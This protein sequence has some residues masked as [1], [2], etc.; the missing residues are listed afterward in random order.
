MPDEKDPRITVNEDEAT[1][2]V[3]LSMNG[4]GAQMVRTDFNPSGLS[5]VDFMKMVVAGCINEIDV[6]GKDPRLT[7]IARTKAEEFAEKAVKSITA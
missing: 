7:A 4:P 2:T 3:T 5:D 6:L 1:I